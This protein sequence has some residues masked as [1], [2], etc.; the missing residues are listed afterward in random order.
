[1]KHA[2]YEYAV[3]VFV[4]LIRSMNSSL[5]YILKHIISKTVSSCL[6]KKQENLRT[7]KTGRHV[8]SFE[9]SAGSGARSIGQE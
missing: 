8:L 9:L 6:E 2:V 4:V 7:G 5:Y 3:E 1:M